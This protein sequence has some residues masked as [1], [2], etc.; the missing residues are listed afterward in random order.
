MAL[1]ITTLPDYLVY[2]NYEG[3][4]GFSIRRTKRTKQAKPYNLPTAYQSSRCYV[5]VA[6]KSQSLPNFIQYA[7]AS[8]STGGAD[9]CDVILPLIAPEKSMAINLA[10]D[11]FLS[12][13]REDAM[14][15]VNWAERKQA[16]GMITERAG[17]LLRFVYAIKRGR[18]GD[19]AKALRL[20]PTETPKRVKWHRTKSVANTFLEYHFGWDPLVKDIYTAC[21]ILSAPVS[22]PKVE[23]TGKKVPFKRAYSDPY[24]TEI[25]EGRVRAAVGA[26]VRVSNPNVWLANQLGLLNPFSVALELIPW[27]FLWDWFFNVSQWVGQLTDTWGLT[28]SDGWYSVKARSKTTIDYSYAPRGEWLHV[29]KESYDFERTLGFPGVT[30]GKLP[31]K[32]LSTV[33]AATAMSLLVQQLPSRLAVPVRPGRG[34]KPIAIPAWSTTDLYSR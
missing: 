30:L 8:G 19:A 21:G 28:L 6:R 26:T 23:V 9:F 14:L 1:P 33:R 13:I 2:A 24:T 22:W 12:A 17:Q 5:T 20:S 34:T 32:R 29:E 7:H 4:G 27:S 3:P 31:S 25:A 15:A 10:R 11:K 18:L 16:I